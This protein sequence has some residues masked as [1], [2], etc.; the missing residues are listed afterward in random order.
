MI[1]T[2]MYKRGDNMS[3]NQQIK[4]YPCYI[5]G[6][7]IGADAASRIPVENPA[8]GEVFAEV[9]QCT[10]EHV[11]HALETSRQAQL[12][13]QARPAIKRAEYIFDLADRLNAERDLFARLLVMEQ[14]KPLAEAYGEVD[15]TVRYLTYNAEAVRRIEGQ[16]FPSDLP[17][18]QLWIQKVPYG[19]TVGLCAFN[20]PLA[21][22]GRKLGPALVTGNTMVLKPHELTP[23]TASEFC[24][25]VDE[26][27][28]PDGVVNMVV[29]T[30]AD[31][32]SALVSSFITK[33]VSV[34]GS[35]RAGQAICEARCPDQGRRSD[36][37]HRHGPRNQRGW[38]C[39]C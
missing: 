4:F 37:E 2:F 19:V 1:T 30:G 22:I 18:E 28:L 29:G 20:Y 26:S 33:L 6:G 16:I 39:P 15:D 9:P 8:T 17:N 7:W 11:Q 24:R 38:S 34:T 23:V 14:G 27:D 31:V 32:G 13:W 21:L 5:N 3:E 36:A 25:L 10:P 35:I 12:K